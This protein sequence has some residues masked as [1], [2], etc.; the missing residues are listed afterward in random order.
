MYRP[1]QDHLDSLVILSPRALE[2]LQ[3]WFNP[4]TVRV[5]VPFSKPHLLLIMDVLVLGWRAHLGNLRT[6]GLWSQAELSLH[7]NVR[8]LARHFMLHF[9]SKFVSV[10]TDNTTMMLS[11]QTGWYL[12]LSPM[13]G[14]RRLW[15]FCIT[16][17]IQ[18]EV[19]YLPG[20]QMNRPIASA[21]LSNAMDGLSN[22]TLSAISS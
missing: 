21:D 14:S 5:G 1:N 17:S 20:A 12:L 13:P 16:Q 2:S 22:R 9:Q 15:N 19:S 4:Q 8:E 3:W 18:L 6:Q 10:L 7:I 11:K